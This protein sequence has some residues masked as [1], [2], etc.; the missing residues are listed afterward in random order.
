MCKADEEATQ[1][2]FVFGLDELVHE[3]GRCHGAEVTSRLAHQQPER[4][5][6][7]RLTRSGIAAQ[8]RRLTAIEIAALGET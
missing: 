2:S 6:Q 1:A 8:H 5:E 7:M 4:D 3:S